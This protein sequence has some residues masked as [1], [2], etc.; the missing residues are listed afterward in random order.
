M[1]FYFNIF[2]KFK[3][4]NIITLAFREFLGIFF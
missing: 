2:E 3:E 4:N 1:A